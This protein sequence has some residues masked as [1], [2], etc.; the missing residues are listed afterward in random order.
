MFDLT[1]H[2]DKFKPLKTRWGR[3]GGG[4]GL[5]LH[6]HQAHHAQAWKPGEPILFDN[7]PESTDM[8]IVNCPH[9][10][11]AWP[12]PGPLYVH[13]ALKAAGFKSSFCDLNLALFKRFE[14]VLGPSASRKEI[15]DY[16]SL[17]DAHKSHQWC[18]SDFVDRFRGAI[19]HIAAGIAAKSPKA[20]GFS[21]N[22]FSK[23]FTIALARAMKR[24]LPELPI[25]F[26]GYD[27][28]YADVL[29]Y[30]SDVA[31]YYVVGEGEEVAPRLLS[32]I[33]NRPESEEA[34]LL[35]GVMVND[36]RGIAS[37]RMALPPQDLNAVAFPRFKDVDLNEYQV[38]GRKFIWVNSSR[39]CN[40]GRCTFC[41]TISPYRSRRP[42]HVFQEINYLYRDHGVR[43]FSFSDQDV[44][45]DPDALLALCDQIIAAGLGPKI[46]LGGDLRIS[47]SC[48]LEF[49]RKLKKAGFWFVDF[50]LES[51]SNRVLKLM[52][53]GISRELAERNLKAAKGAG[54]GVG[55]N[56]MVGFPGERYE[57]FADTLQWLLAM[58]AYYDVIGGLTTTAIHRRS[59]LFDH[60][61]E[62]GVA[63]GETKDWIVYDWTM[64]TDP[65]N[66]LKNRCLRLEI[67][68]RLL[69]P[70]GID[71]GR[72]VADIR[73][74]VSELGADELALWRFVEDRLGIHLPEGAVQSPNTNLFSR[75]WRYFRRCGF[76][77]AFRISVDFARR[78]IR[79][80]L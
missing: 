60:R 9:W 80:S 13:E 18:Q 54:L 14:L 40:W 52:K 79:G 19:D 47:K 44:N 20:I 38:E 51:A 2:R 70:L 69:I 55:I 12:P 28:F 77:S 64:S 24:L 39:G 43:R 50:G 53:K 73:I 33:L 6:P 71:L 46:T 29:P 45:N 23:T 66:T 1:V 36:Q 74:P 61:D 11:V 4:D 22:M 5:S 26:G 78:R 10:N 34:Y 17:W 7:L 16:Q 35:P 75:G 27:C 76:A 63:F 49:F 67:I 25:I 31:D 57:D 41:S 62:F 30:Y 72:T 37:F 56:L 42:E 15:R 21:V 65:R 59:Y 8:I 48:T 3:F 32:T 68:R 58:K